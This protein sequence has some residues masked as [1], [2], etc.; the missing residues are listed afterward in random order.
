MYPTRRYDS[1]A[2]HLVVLLGIGV[3]AVSAEAVGTLRIDLFH[4]GTATTEHFSL[5]RI[6]L[7][8]LP[9]AG[10][11]ARPADD[12]NL[13]K[14]SFEVID[15]ASNRLLYL[16]G[17]ASI[18]GEWET[19]DE[20][21][22]RART[23]EESLRFPVPPGPIQVVVKK[24]DATN[25]FHEVWSLLVNPTDPAIDRST[26]PSA[27]PVVPL[28]QNGDSSSKVDLLILGDGYTAAER[29]KFEADARR[30]VDILFA[31]SPF[32]ERRADFNVWGLA[33]GC[34]VGHLTPQHGH[35]APLSGRRAVRRVRVGTLRPHFRQS[36]FPRLREPGAVRVVEI[37]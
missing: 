16:R 11:P 35:V 6:V 22:E 21:R 20:A 27:G 9:W 8:P 2:S 26:P 37:W 28:V 10:N 12:T 33:P 4:T 36:R 19:T 24:R 23:F 31:T 14:Y 34:R 17:Y 1:I 32:K 13:G 5:A 7:E 29:T 30:L 18:Y 15:R 25:A 3:G